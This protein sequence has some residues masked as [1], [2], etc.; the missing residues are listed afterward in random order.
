MTIV[1]LR[2]DILNAKREKDKEKT[3]VLTTFLE[4]ALKIAKDDG[5]REVTDQDLISSVKKEIKMATEAKDKGAPYSELV[6]EI[7]NKIL[8]KKM[9]ER[10]L[11]VT[12]E[13]IVEDLDGKPNIGSIMKELK[14]YGD[15]V[16]MKMANIIIKEIIG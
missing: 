11:R 16:D 6:F 4:V 15:S 14:T 7:G 13:T 9:S 8:P 3:L 1:D 10:E 5:N 2:K 12:I